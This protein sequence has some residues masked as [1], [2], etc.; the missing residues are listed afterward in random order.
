MYET[1]SSP[2]M[3]RVKGGFLKSLEKHVAVI[4]AFG[5]ETQVDVF[6]SA[7]ASALAVPLTVLIENVR[8]Q[9]VTIT[10]QNGTVRHVI[11][12]ESSILFELTD[13]SRQT[14]TIK[15]SHPT[16]AFDFFFLGDV[17]GMFHHL[18]EVIQA[19]NTLDPLFIMS[20]GDMTHSGHLE[21][22]HR[23]SDLL[24]TSHVPVFTSIGNHDKRARGGRANYRKLL[25][26]LYYSFAM[27]DTKFIVL[28]SS[29]KRGLQK[30]QYAWLEQELQQAKGMRTFVFL[31]RPPVCPKYNYLAFSASSNAW[32]FLALMEQYHV[33]M[34]LASHIHVF[35]EFYKRGVHYIITGGGGGALWQPANIHHYLHVFVKKNGVDVKVIPLPT[36]EAKMSQRLKDVIKF[37]VEYHITKKKHFKFTNGLGASKRIN[38]ST[39]SERFRIRR[40]GV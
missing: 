37:N 2:P 17:H 30:F 40:R 31:H 33:E 34:V 28:D 38:R 3:I 14:L 12:S 39:S 5:F 27:R 35:T 8:G 15:Y 16:N 23:L 6:Q 18:R 32:K 29:R 26:P 25:S 13:C 7:A 4:R 36:P 21:D 22:Y 20:N 24:G 9:E 10:H 19:G 1:L 11:R